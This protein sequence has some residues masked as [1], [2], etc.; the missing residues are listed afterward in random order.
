MLRRRNKKKIILRYFK[1]K[2]LKIFDK[3][4]ILSLEKDE[5]C[6]EG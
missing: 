3:G 2:L 4:K 5:I 6:I 1:I